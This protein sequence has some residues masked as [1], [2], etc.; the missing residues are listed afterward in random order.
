MLK[1]VISKGLELLL[2]SFNDDS[3]LELRNK[4]GLTPL[5]VAARNEDSLSTRYIA[6]NFLTPLMTDFVLWTALH[7]YATWQLGY[8]VPPSTKKCAQTIPSQM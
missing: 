6:Y 2:S 1:I 3:L 4:R 8:L 5:H 7:S